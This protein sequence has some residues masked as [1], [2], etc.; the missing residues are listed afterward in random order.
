MNRIRI[1]AF[2][3]IVGL[4]S[5]PRTG[6][7]QGGLIDRTR[8]RMAL[9]QVTCQYWTIED[10]KILQLSLPISV[11]YPV[12]DRLLVNLNTSP[13]YNSVG[14]GE[15][16]SLSGLS[17]T[18]LSGSYLFGGD[19]LLA[20]FG[21]NL[22]SGKHALDLEETAVADTIALRALDMQ[23]PILGQ[24]FECTAGLVSAQRLSG[25]VLGYGAGFLFRSPFAPL[26]NAQEKYNPGE[27][28]T[29]SL[30][31]DYPMRQGR[32]LM[33]DANYT[34]FTADKIENDEVFKSGNRLTVQGMV[35]LPGEKY[36]WLINIKD[37]LRSKNEIQEGGKLIPERQNSNGNELEAAIT[38]LMPV[39]QKLTARLGL[40]GRFYSNNAYDLG[41]A[42]LVGI[43]AGA[44]IRLAANV[45]LDADG[46]FYSGSMDTGSATANMTGFR[47]LTGLRIIL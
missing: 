10:T 24:G 35:Y 47:L 46:R 9:P 41:G 8:E 23:T 2:A 4:L 28:F 11:V 31:I 33:F 32:K 19:R 16:I 15:S 39:S 38:T 30:G 42:A 26:K 14:D 40:E 29:L 25:L 7:A 17:D 27:E 22:P 1:L 3:S 6:Y 21:V 5:L 44:R 43:G 36:N 34:L 45:S 13:A 18:R 37:R 20:T 12:N